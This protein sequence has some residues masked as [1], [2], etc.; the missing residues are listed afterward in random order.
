M[1]QRVQ[2]VYL[3]LVVVFSVLFFF[4]PLGV[5]SSEEMEGAI[6]LIGRNL[7]AENFQ[8]EYSGFYRWVLIGITLVA[9]SLSL[10]IIFQFRSRLYQVR[11]CRINILFYLVQLV[12]AFFYLD[13]LK[14]ALA[15]SSFSY[16]PA[17][18]F[19]LVSLFLLL[20]AIRS[21]KKDEALVRAA[22]RIR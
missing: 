2:S 7:S 13:Q 1:L 3:F 22:D 12:V 14:S 9:I 16:G 18:Y 15:L 10:F 5:F 11:L 21:I 19:P 8:I 4:F 6:R 17:I 20:L